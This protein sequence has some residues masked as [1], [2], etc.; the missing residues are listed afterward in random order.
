M[1]MGLSLNE[2]SVLHR[3]VYS[4]EALT[5]I[6]AFRLFHPPASTRP[7]MG[8]KSDPAQIKMNCSTSLKIAERKPPSVTKIATVMDEIQILKL[9]SQ[10]ST[11]FITSAMEYMLMPLINTVMNAKEMAERARLDSPKRNFR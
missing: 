11:T 9:M 5:A 10:P 8:I 1:P 3:W 2:P 6:L 7:R 4:L